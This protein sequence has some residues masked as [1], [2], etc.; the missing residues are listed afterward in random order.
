MRPALLTPAPAT[1]DTDLLWALASVLAL[2]AV[3]SAVTCLCRG[4]GIARRRAADRRWLDACR[5]SLGA[6]DS[7]SPLIGASPR[8][9]VFTVV[10]LCRSVTGAD[11]ERVVDW[12]DQ[13]GL[14]DRALRWASSWSWTVRVRGARV[15]ATLANHPEVLARMF[16]DRRPEVRRQA[17]EHSS[18]PLTP[19]V[20]SGLLRLLDD[21]D[22]GVRFVACDT[23]A[24][25]GKSS[26]PYLAMGLGSPHP[27]VVG[28][29]LRAA[30]TNLDPALLPG[31]TALCGSTDPQERAGGVS[32]LA[33]LHAPGTAA[34]IRF[35]LNDP[36]EVVR[37]AAA[38]G[39]GRLRDALA[40]GQVAEL[41]TDPSWQV[42]RAA[43]F[44]LYRLGAPGTV[45]L[46]AALRSQDPYATDM[47]RLVIAAVEVNP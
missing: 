13:A 28:G 40:A 4:A 36:D 5:V 43:G 29:A 27:R 10:A 1:I 18:S 24:R 31:A 47:A 41:L 16:S 9:Q 2:I 23:L 14:T 7:T 19:E 46:R 35:F 11:K 38:T 34:A 44:A 45:M 20:L 32:L 26:A 17:A 39:L 25:G 3:V 33:L 30:M 37:A 12:A 6:A 42:R 8:R 21:H 15:L 22:P